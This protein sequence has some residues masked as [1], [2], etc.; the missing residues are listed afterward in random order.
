MRWMLLIMPFLVVSCAHAFR[1]L[2]D[3]R[4]SCR[5]MCNKQVKIHSPATGECECFKPIRRK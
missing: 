3:D 4:L 5:T 1:S 2:E